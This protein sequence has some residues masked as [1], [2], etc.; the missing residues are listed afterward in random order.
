MSMMGNGRIG[1]PFTT[2][3]DPGV[4]DV[5]LVGSFTNWAAH[6]IVMKADGPG[7]WTAQVDLPPGDYEYRLLIDGQWADDPCAPKQGQNNIRKVCAEESSLHIV[8]F[9]D[10]NGSGLPHGQK[11]L[12]GVKVSIYDEHGRLLATPTSNACGCIDEPLKATGLLRL[13]PETTACDG[14]Q[15]LFTALADG[16]LIQ[17]DQGQVSGVDIPYRKGLAELRAAARLIPAGSAGHDT[18]LP[19]V[20]FSLYKG[21]AVQHQAYRTATT[22]AWAPE[23]VFGDLVE[24]TYVLTASLVNLEYQGQR[25]EHDQPSAG[26][27]P[28]IQLRAAQVMDLR[29]RFSFK[30]VTNELTGR[31]LDADTGDGVV[32]AP[33]SLY[34]KDRSSPPKQVHTVCGGE[35]RC[36]QLAPGTYSV[37]LGADKFTAGN[38]K[39]AATQAGQQFEVTLT[40]TSRPR[41]LEF[42]VRRDVPRILIDVTDPGG[43]RH[44]HAV[45]DIYDASQKLIDSVV[46]GEDGRLAWVAPA[47][48]RYYVA[49]QLNPG[50]APAKLYPADVHSDAPVTIP[51]Q[52]LLD[53][54]GTTPVGA[55]GS[56]PT[57]SVVDATAYPILTEEVSFP[58]PGPR[59][60]GPGAS[61]AT[62]LGPAVESALRDVLGWRPKTTDPKGFTAALTQS[63]AL[64]DVEGHTEAT[65]VPRSYAVQVQADMGAITG[66][67][68]SIYARAKVALDQ[69]LP[70]LAGLTS[71]RADI[72]P[73]DQEAM[74][75]IV[76]SELPQLVTELGVEGGPRVQRVDELF[77]Y[78]LGVQS[79]PPGT[80]PVSPT[81]EAL[82]GT[83]DKPRS[84]H[85]GE[86]GR[87][88]GMKRSIVNTIDD[89][90]DLTNFIILV[91][92]VSGLWQSWIAQR[93]FFDRLNDPG[94]E[95]FL[96][97]QL[98]LVSRALAVVAESIQEVNFTLDSVFVGPAERQTLQLNFGKKSFQV[99]HLPLDGTKVTVT[100]GP[101][102]NSPLFVAE[103]LDWIDRVASEEGPRFIQDSGK[104][105]VSALSPTI[106]KLRKFARGALVR[107]QGGEQDPAAVPA[108]YKTPRVQRSIREL[109]DALDE[110]GNLAVS[111]K[112]PS[113]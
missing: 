58:T 84:T 111:I 106:D 19:G 60:P 43:N 97:T 59:P 75:S 27:L 72:L 81:A 22:T 70:L 53:G 39:W 17:A 71:L 64:K 16:I 50:G 109:A 38:V 30:P 11:R 83:Q 92:Y 107:G 99:P 10:E 105:G 63:F 5:Q 12:A 62:A 87:R 94:A 24:G 4:R 85:L 18:Y 54:R 51:L 36:P 52:D 56:D 1:V 103:L 49:P 82:V 13:L 77:G 15:Q 108:G 68:A 102:D 45:V 41:P 37:R 78:L 69:S 86:L 20:L 112:P 31:V 35:F 26:T 73:E 66:A 21:I 46:V 93:K 48:G 101:P 7:I 100:L 80:T 76:R 9:R 90:Q 33:V 88:F 67:Q 40:A 42:H 32:N 61:G 8:V 28:P 96:G 113:I 44:R 29:G 3:T 104:D 6:P 98:V 57:E 74:R 65:W 89:E 91:D 110:V 25:L 95:P 47:E 23:A 79:P 34:G 2:V 14:P 55:N